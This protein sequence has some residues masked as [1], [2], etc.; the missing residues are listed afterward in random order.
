ME[1][2]TALTALGQKV[3]DLENEVQELRASNEQ[4]QV[5]LN[6]R[7]MMTDVLHENEQQFRALVA[8]IPGAVYRIRLG[9][10][11][12]IE[13]ISDAIEEITAFPGSHFRWQP[14]QAYR[15]II[16]PEDR[17]NVEKAIREG[18]EPLHTFSVEYRVTDA[19][20]KPRWFLEAGQ[21]VYSTKG[22]PLWLDGVISDISERK[23][24]QHALLKANRKLE[25]LAS[26]DGLTQIANRR[27]FDE[28]LEREWHR[29][30]REK[31]T[32]SLILSDIDWFK[33]YNDNYGHQEGDRC[34]QEVAEAIR[35]TER[36]P[37]DFSA[38]YGGEEFV[39]VL[40]D[41]DAQ[42]ALYV[43]EM[44]GKAVSSLK[45]PHDHSKV[46]QYITLSLG[47]ASV[48]PN[49]E[50][51]PENLINAADQAL[52]KAKEQGRNRAVLNTDFP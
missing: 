20:G 46:D 7:V 33:L 47:A 3:K 35:S 51:H 13:F 36:R 28:Y 32:L 37:A 43:A 8:S 48:V 50:L 38:R 16:L 25:R 44:I 5:E 31:K 52:Y 11:W 29:M 4:L 41:T 40:P 17:E 2:T 27:Q 22:D 23:F 18:M 24:A 30:K 26:I 12:I 6:E 21:A 42:G 49:D 45:I 9:T 1:S 15:D 19:D 14:V 34:L 10:D 39:V